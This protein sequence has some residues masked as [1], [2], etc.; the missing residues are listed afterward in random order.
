M[1]EAKAGIAGA[2]RESNTYITIL[3]AEVARDGMGDVKRKW[4]WVRINNDE[5]VVGVND[6][7]AS[8]VNE[9]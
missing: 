8:I 9:E 5:Q 4:L 2:I 3:V 7:I 1:L 6:I